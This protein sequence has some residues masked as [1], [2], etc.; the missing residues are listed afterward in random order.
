MNNRLSRI[1]IGLVF[2]SLPSWAH[3]SFLA[4]FD[5]NQPVSLS[6]TVTTVEWVN[7]HAWIHLDVKGSD[8]TVTNWSIEG[9]TPNTLLRRGFTKESLKPGTEIL[10]QGYQARKGGPVA[11]GSSITFK[12]GRKVFLGSSAPEQADK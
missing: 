6:G 10:V 4:E 3:H 7:P 2:S 9:S 11:N 1:I 5:I 8:G 12:D